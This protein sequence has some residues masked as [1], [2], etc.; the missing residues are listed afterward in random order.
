MVINNENGYKAVDYTKLGPILI[1]AVK[2]QQKKIETLE[3]DNMNLKLRL[4]KLESVVNSLT[5]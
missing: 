3:N 4:E 2:E 1:E 5:K